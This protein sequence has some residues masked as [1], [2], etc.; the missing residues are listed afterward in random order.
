MIFLRKQLTYR[1]N[2]LKNGRLFVVKRKK[3]IL[4]RIIMECLSV[5][6]IFFFL[7]RKF[8][9]TKIK[10]ERINNSFTSEK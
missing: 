3:I 10:K 5:I 4:Y 7:E 9:E 6:I 8:K 2:I 1:I